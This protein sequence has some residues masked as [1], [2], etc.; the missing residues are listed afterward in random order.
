MKSKREQYQKVLSKYLPEEF[1]D[2][3]VELLV[4]HPVAFKIVKPRKTKLGDF[5]VNSRTEK[6]Q[7]TVN[8]DLNKYSFLITTL[9]EFAHLINFKENGKKCTKRD[10]DF[11]FNLPKNI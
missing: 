8:G 5:R 3:V 7:I 2:M 10:S 9:H 6:P 11:H 1:I 4:T